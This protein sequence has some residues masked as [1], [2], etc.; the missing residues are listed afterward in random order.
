MPGPWTRPGDRF[1]K[2]IVMKLKNVL[3]ILVALVFVFASSCKERGEDEEQENAALKAKGQVVEKAEAEEADEA[4]EAE[5]GEEGE[6]AAAPVV[7]LEILPAVVLEAFK[8]A[9][10][11]AV[12]KGTD[13]ETE[14]GVTYYEIESVDG[15]TAR[16]LLYT[17]DGK[18]HE[19]EEAI[20]PGALPVAVRQAVEAAYPGC[21][22][23]KAEVT[24]EGGK[25]YELQ[26]EAAGK[27]MGVT[28]GPDG[29]MIK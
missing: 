13:K 1:G 27:T 10:P 7:N 16:N 29:K 11:Q 8:T 20:E 28:V 6:E 25:T 18:V 15:E 21:K 17:A 22:I 5:E 3:V 9:Y 23:L 2:E 14:N 24:T 4:E 19:I 26:I 12:I